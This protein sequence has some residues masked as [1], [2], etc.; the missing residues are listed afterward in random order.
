MASFYYENTWD[1][2]FSDKNLSDVVSVS[3][4]HTVYDFKTG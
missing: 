4:V 1:D 3:M 2:I